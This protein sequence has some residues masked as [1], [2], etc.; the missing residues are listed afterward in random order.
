MC[1]RML[2]RSEKVLTIPGWAGVDK[3]DFGDM[4]V[5]FADKYDNDS[6]SRKKYI[7]I[8]G[9][10]KSDRL[11]FDQYAVQEWVRLRNAEIR[12]KIAARLYEGL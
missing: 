5:M 6:D 10:K 1:S 7:K 12:R 11:I 9:G 8:K 4:I 3:R 2:L